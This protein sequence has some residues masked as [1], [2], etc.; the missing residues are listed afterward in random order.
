MMKERRSKP[1][2]EKQ[3]RGF[4]NLDGEMVEIKVRD[5]AEVGVGVNASRHFREGQ[6]G[7]L[8]VKEGSKVEELLG[9]VCWCMLDPMSDDARYPYRAGIR[10]L[11]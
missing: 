5:A 1:R 3:M 4:F 11:A 2:K 10:V 7:V 6:Q 9:E 8:L